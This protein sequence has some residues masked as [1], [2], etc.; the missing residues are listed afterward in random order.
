MLFPRF[1]NSSV[2][3]DKL[4]NFFSFFLSFSVVSPKSK[5]KQMLFAVSQGS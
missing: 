3:Y 5:S 2:F 1:D 4:H